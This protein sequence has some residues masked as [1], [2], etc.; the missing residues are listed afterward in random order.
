MRAVINCVISAVVSILLSAIISFAGRG[1]LGT[2][3]SKTA[4]ATTVSA[5]ETADKLPSETAPV[6]SESTEIVSETFQS[7][8]ETTSP[9]AETEVTAD[10]DIS[11]ETETSTAVVGL[12][13]SGTS[14][15]AFENTVPKPTVQESINVEKTVRRL[16]RSQ[17]YNQSEYVHVKQ[18]EY[19]EPL[20]ITGCETYDGGFEY[21]YR[22]VSEDNN[23]YIYDGNEGVFGYFEY[24]NA[25]SNQEIRS[26]MHTGTLE[27]EYGIP[28]GSAEFFTALTSASTGI[29][30]LSYSDDLTPGIYIYT[31]EHD[32]EGD[33]F[34]AEFILEIYEKEKTEEPVEPTED[35]VEE[36]ISNL[37]IVNIKPSRLCITDAEFF[38][39]P[40]RYEYESEGESGY[41]SEMDYGIKG[42]FEYS[43]PLTAR[44]ERTFGHGGKILNSS[45]KECP[46]ATFFSFLTSEQDGFFMMQYPDNL[47]SGEYTFIL[48]HYID[49]VYNEARIQFTVD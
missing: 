40:Y 2:S 28:C 23:I 11:T 29:F 42:T 3:I 5:T 9:A 18:C 4:V 1:S 25:L 10:A 19:E 45:G 32:I 49:N 47:K 33:T 22:S 12:T 13:V 6:S 38:D 21:E 17:I 46:G 48:Y 44:E 24:T 14:E 15:S 34:M 43:S 30:G 37:E 35:R 20:K 36:S 27:D 31:L 39:S 16:S 7:V 41:F 26:F 8:S